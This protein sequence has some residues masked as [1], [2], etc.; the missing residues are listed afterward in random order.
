VIRDTVQHESLICVIPVV[1]DQESFLDDFFETPWPD[2][3]IYQS[4]K[5]RDAAIEENLDGGGF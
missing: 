5:L 2:T 4:L 3:S 1:I